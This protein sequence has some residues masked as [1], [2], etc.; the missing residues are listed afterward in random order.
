MVLN[1]KIFFFFYFFISKR[2]FKWFRFNVLLLVRKP[3]KTH[4]TLTRLELK[5][6]ISL[7]FNINA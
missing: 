3:N 6:K 1:E 2:I 4:K 7:Q 5:R